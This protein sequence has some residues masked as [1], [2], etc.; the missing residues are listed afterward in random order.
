MLREMLKAFIERASAGNI[1]QDEKSFL[2]MLIKMTDADKSYIFYSDADEEDIYLRITAICDPA[3]IEIVAERYIGYPYV[4]VSLISRNPNIDNIARSSTLA[5][6]GVFSTIIDNRTTFVISN[7]SQVK[8][9]EDNCDVSDYDI[10]F[11]WPWAIFK[12]NKENLLVTSDVAGNNQRVIMATGQRQIDNVVEYFNGFTVE[13]IVKYRKDLISECKKYS[14]DILVVSDNI[15][16]KEELISILIKVKYAVPNIRIIYFTSEIGPREDVRRNL[17]SV[18]IELGVYDIMFDNKFSVDILKYLLGNP[19]PKSAVEKLI[20]K[21]NMTKVKGSEIEIV[22]RDDDVGSALLHAKANV[23]S[24]IS[25]KGGTGKTFIAGN[26]ARAI[27]KSGIAND[28]NKVKVALI[29]GDLQGGE[30]TNQLHMDEN[31]IKDKNIITAIAHAAQ[32]VKNGQVVA[33]DVQK[34]LAI[35]KIKECFVS[36]SDNSNLKVLS[37]SPTYLTDE[38]FKA[39]NGEYIQFIVE[40]I[41]DDYD[42]ILIDITG[43]FEL[44]IWFPIFTLSRYVF[45][46]V[47][48]EFNSMSSAVRQ[49]AIIENFV[50]NKKKV[51]YIFNKTIDSELVLYG[52]KEIKDEEIF[53]ISGEIP[54]VDRIR[55]INNTF[56]GKWL[57]DDDSKD[58]KNVRMSLINVAS[59]I[60]PIKGYE[61]LVDKDEA[62]EESDTKNNEE[63]KDWK[64]TVKEGLKILFPFADEAEKK[65]KQKRG[66]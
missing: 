9:I 41:V 37:A 49:E 63:Q 42:V 18:L 31:K 53:D 44:N 27:A 11:S 6:L 56:E 36:S 7:K 22:G 30:L 24:F 48:M 43:D 51:R 3:D 59:T 10:C 29:D 14:P 66:G 4:D 55:M 28:G 13:T 16:G 64:Q 58:T 39:I 21:K 26:V 19:K 23:Y 60:W 33:D 20:V 1:E 15:G 32:I 47:E 57:V 45:S 40:S 65:M 12:K 8:A 5:S 50:G 46:V 62:E 38:E 2:N 35:E 34:E 17:I 25:S 54:M 61:N 52:M